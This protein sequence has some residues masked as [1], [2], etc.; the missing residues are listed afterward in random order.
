MKVAAQIA[1]ARPRVTLG[2]KGV[3]QSNPLVQWGSANDLP[4]D[5]RLVFFLKT[6]IPARF[7]RDE[8]VEVAAED[9]SFRTTLSVADGSMLLSDARTAMLSLE[10]LTRFGSSAFGPIQVRVLSA[11]GAAGDWLPLGTL[12]RLPAFKELRC[13]RAAAKA[14]TL[15]GNNLFLI[16]S[17]AT[18]PDFA[19]PVEVPAEFTGAEL[20]VP[21]P[22]AGGLQIRLRD[23]PDTVQTLSLPILPAGGDFKA[24]TA[25]APAAAAPASASQEPAK[26]SETTA[27]SKAAPAAPVA[28]AAKTGDTA[29]TAATSDKPTAPATAPAGAPEPKQP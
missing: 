25:P 1:P 20:T 14:C 21:H 2:K 6:V 22:A 26:D 11:S 18:A 17:L 12:V 9:G 7:P 24:E 3:Q 15:T 5:G 27:P 13:P 19:N 10:P 28:E 29:T 8:K 16:A 4:L 23:D